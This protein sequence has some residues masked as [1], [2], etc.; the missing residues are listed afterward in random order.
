MNN[1]EFK[2][3]QMI[4]INEAA[5]AS[6]MSYCSIRKLCIEGKIQYIRVGADPSRGKFLINQRSLYNFLNGVHQ[7]NTLYDPQ[8]K[9]SR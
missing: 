2:L 3:P 5:E 7:E 9:E 6:N 1:N 8:E 4:T